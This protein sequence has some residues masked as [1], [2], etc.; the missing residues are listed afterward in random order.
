M[1]PRVLH[2]LDAASAGGVACAAALVADL[3]AAD[4]RHRH[5]LLLFGTARDAAAARASGLAPLATLAPPLGEA[6]C[7][8]RGLAALLAPLD[9]DALVA[10]GIGALAAALS[11]PFAGRPPLSFVAVVGPHR[12]AAAA[13]ARRALER[14]SVPAVALDAAIACEVEETLGIAASVVE[15]PIDRARLDADRAAIRASWDADDGMLV[16]ALATAPAAWGDA[17]RAADAVGIPRVRGARV[18]LLVHP[19]SARLGATRAWLGQLGLDAILRTEPRLERP[20]SMLSGVDLLLRCGDGVRTCGAAA[21]GGRRGATA[22][23]TSLAPRATSPLP[24]LWA[25]AAGVPLLDAQS[26]A[27]LDG[28]ARHGHRVAISRGILAACGMAGDAAPPTAQP[29]PAGCDPARSVGAW[30]RALRLPAPSVALS[31]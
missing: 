4:P 1:T 28:A 22:R 14:R 24:E 27:R 7:A 16:V 8:R 25:R 30:S 13:F 12:S 19:A 5:A 29:L 23:W 31:R 11:M 2:L 17:R 9:A 6:I 21:D 10:W 18:R 20:W 3:A 26:A 15:P